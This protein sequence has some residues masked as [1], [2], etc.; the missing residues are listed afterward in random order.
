MTGLP[1]GYRLR[2]ASLADIPA[3]Q[4]VLD[5]AESA[6]CG[7]PR[8]HEN[9]LELD[10][11][12]PHVDL[13]RDAWVVSAPAESA[14]PIVAVALVLR[15][16]ASGE[17]AADQYVHPEHRGRGICA[18]LLDA[19]EARAVELAATLAAGV[20]ATLV[21]WAEP[22][23]AEY[24]AP[25][26]ARGFAATRQYF[27]MRIDLGDELEIP[28]WPDGITPRPLRVG[29]DEPQLHAADTEAF[30]E[31][32][33]FEPRPYAEWRF[34]HVDRPDFDPG[35]WP[36]GWDGDEIAGYAAALV[37]DDGGMVGDLAVR[38]PWRGRGLGLALLLEEFRA[39]AARGVT[40]VRLYVDGQNATGAVALYEKAGMHIARRFDVLEKR[41]TPVAP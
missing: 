14:D 34:H 2:H 33:M 1:K 3:A 6:D 10:F 40:V 36:I 7:E 27:E 25:L 38:R 41:L 8:R 21:V 9:R 5:A 26:E 22:A 12:D 17:I 15:P 28:R 11:R 18:A 32:H 23:V 37:A 30:A 24:S 4:R 20:S 39:L 19:I 29:R 13:A 35:L 31:H 16:H